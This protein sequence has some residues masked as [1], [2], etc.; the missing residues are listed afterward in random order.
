MISY[1]PPHPKRTPKCHP[2]GSDTD[3][4]VMR[5]LALIDIERFARFDC[6]I[7]KVRELTHDRP[8]TAFGAS[9][10]ALS[11]SPNIFSDYYV[12]VPTTPAC[13]SV[14]Y[15]RVPRAAHHRK[16]PQQS[17]RIVAALG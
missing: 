3:V 5:W 13:K 4:K 10:A 9:L 15:C 8:P 11:L 7:V 14:A 2:K 16:F 6:R 12:A 1:L 17:C